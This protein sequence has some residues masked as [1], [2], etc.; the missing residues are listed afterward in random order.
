VTNDFGE[1]RVG[2]I[3]RTIETAG[4]SLAYAFPACSIT[5][6]RAVVGA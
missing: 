2:V 3:E 5:V 1:E 4:D 6:L